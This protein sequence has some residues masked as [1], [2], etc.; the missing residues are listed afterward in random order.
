MN[1]RLLLPKF[2]IMGIKKNGA[3]YRPYIMTIIFASAIYFMFSSIVA[4]PIMKTVP[5]AGYAIML[6]EIGKV[7]LGM[8]LIPF[9]VYT[10]SFLFKRRKKELGLYTVLGLEKKHVGVML[11]IESFILFVISIGGG[12]IIAIVFSKLLFLILLK[13]TNLPPETSFVLIPGSFIGTAKLFGFIFLINLISNIW[14][15]VKTNSTQ[16]LQGEKK[17]EKEPKHLVLDSVLGVLFLACGYLVS[18]FAKLDSM[19]FVKFPVAVIL[20]IIGTYFLFTAGIVQYLKH[21]KK[22]K[23]LYYQKENYVT[24]SGMLYRMKKSAAGLVN[25]CLFSTMIIVTLTCTVA[26][27]LGEEGSITFFNPF[28][29]TYTF[30][31]EQG[32]VQKKFSED[33]EKEAAKN[34]VIRK[35]INN[36]TYA[37]MDLTKKD[38]AFGVDEK[39]GLQDDDCSFRILTLDT[40][41]RIENTNRTLNEDECLLFY[42]AGNYNYQKIDFL[43]HPFKV[44]EELNRIRIDNKDEHTVSHRYYYL[45]VKDEMVLSEI[46]DKNNRYNSL[47]FNME[48]TETDI[49][50]FLTEADLI[51]QNTGCSF[52]SQNYY[53]YGDR[54]KSMNG[55]LL[56]IGIFF[57]LV[58]AAAL[59]LVMYYKQISEGLEDQDSFHIMKKVGMSKEDINATIKKQI[60]LVFAL[61][62]LAAIFHICAALPMLINLMYALNLYKTMSTVISLMIVLAAYL[63]FYG[64]SYLATAKTYY[65]IVQ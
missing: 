13:M 12:L 27:T 47:V 55:G 5:Y 6:L 50:A 51:Y 31:G 32:E 25:I 29:A 40:F 4:N 63:V 38:S 61:P 56:F 8:V 35:D 2:A 58:F 18:I 64:I 19:I 16:L 17:G 33:L 23:N 24:I 7:L 11:F 28:D 65:K 60:L 62:A 44:K 20:V 54:T 42:T 36:Y 22:N 52:R 15:V 30:I 59:I 9:L 10:N 41:N 21:L 26:L 3:L 1:R 43:N 46:C 45:I 49:R 53:E 37:A 57:G 48:G 34:N 14:Q 39:E